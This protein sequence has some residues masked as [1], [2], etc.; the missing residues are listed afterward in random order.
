MMAVGHPETLDIEPTHTATYGRRVRF[1]CIVMSLVAT[2]YLFQMVTPLRL[3]ADTVVLLS[4]A[5]SVAHGGGFLIHGRPT[6]FPPG[7]PAFVAL[8]QRL[9]FAHNWVFVGFNVLSLFVGLWAVS[10][11][12]RRM[13]NAIVPVW[14]V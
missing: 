1:Y 10:H 5:D 3:D 7:Y 13:F 12:L 8:L 6:V 2:G 11:V 4:V 9:G 14:A